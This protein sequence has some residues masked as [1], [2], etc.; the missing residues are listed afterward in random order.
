MRIRRRPGRWV[1]VL[2]GF[3]PP[4]VVGALFVVLF[5]FAWN[6]H[7]GGIL[8][9]WVLL[10]MDRSHSWEALP[11][12]RASGGDVK[13]SDLRPGDTLERVDL[14]N[15]DLRYAKLERIRFIGCNFRNVCGRSSGLRGSGFYNCD[16]RGIDLR[17]AD[18]RGSSLYGVN[19]TG[20]NL[21]FADLASS[22]YSAET[23]WPAGYEPRNH[24]ARLCSP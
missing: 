3:S 5:I 12:R 20:A 13:L 2:D 4:R 10:G 9:F 14:S 15:S 18:L 11:V 16:M 8:R 17:G 24:G 23:R 6:V 1:G 19:L 22:D 21:A 7:T